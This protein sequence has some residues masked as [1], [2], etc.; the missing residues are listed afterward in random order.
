MSAPTD[1]LISQVVEVCTVAPARAALALSK[2]QNSVEHAVNWIY[3]NPEEPEAPPVLPAP[4][5]NLHAPQSDC[6]TQEL[7]SY[8][9][10][11][12]LAVRVLMG[13]VLVEAIE[14][15]L[16]TI[17]TAFYVFHLAFDYLTA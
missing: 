6:I 15:P 11:R 14:V 9:R 12:P 16:D 13:L 8:S 1:D 17:R 10:R 3:E 4:T 7:E 5:S 2:C